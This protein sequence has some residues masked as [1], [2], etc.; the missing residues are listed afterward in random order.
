MSDERCKVPYVRPPRPNRQEIQ[1]AIDEA[2]ERAARDGLIENSGERRWSNRTSR[3]EIVWRS[4]IFGQLQPDGSE[5]GGRS[6]D[7]AAN[8]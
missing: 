5:E 1:K 4:K 3:Y 8:G 7:R 2:L 6:D